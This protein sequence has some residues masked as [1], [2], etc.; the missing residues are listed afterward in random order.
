[1][2]LLT[3]LSLGKVKSTLDKLWRTRE[4]IYHNPAD[5]TYRFYAGGFGIDELRRRIREEASNKTSSITR[6]EAH[7]QLHIVQYAGSD[8]TPTRFVKSNRLCSEDW[9]FQN[10][11]FTVAKFEKA[12][13]S[14]QT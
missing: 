5:N 4:V 7:C 14:E 2:S 3:G 12:L 9:Q 10:Q 1:M 6:L 11:V 8:T 13:F